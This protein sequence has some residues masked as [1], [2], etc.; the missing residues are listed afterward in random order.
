M[1]DVLFN[2]G[3]NLPRHTAFTVKGKSNLKLLA[4]QLHIWII[5]IE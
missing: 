5:L 4:I 1:I 2:F 3:A